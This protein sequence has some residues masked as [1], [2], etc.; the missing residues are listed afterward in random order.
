MQA[1]KQ[2][3]KGFHQ[4]G[5]GVV[6]PCYFEVHIKPE[7]VAE[8][9]QYLKDFFAAFEGTESLDLDDKSLSCP[10]DGCLI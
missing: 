9:I 8:V 6:I 2:N 5:G 7:H 1:F 3:P 4:R 10:F